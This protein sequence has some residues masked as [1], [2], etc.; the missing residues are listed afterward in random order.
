MNNDGVERLRFLLSGIAAP[1]LNNPPSN[2][3][4]IQFPLSHHT[5]PTFSFPPTP[6]LI[7]NQ[8]NELNF[9]NEHLERVALI[10]KLVK[11]Q[12]DYEEKLLGPVIK[13]EKEIKRLESEL[14]GLDI[15]LNA[16]VTVAE[17]KRSLKLEMAKAKMSK[18]NQVKSIQEKMVEF[19]R[20]QQDA[21]K[22]AGFPLFAVSDKLDDLVK[23]HWILAPYMQELQMKQ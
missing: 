21:L 20:Y 19:R 15:I 8:F 22:S 12:E 6:T 11:E 3:S 9:K 7:S 13:L 14:E 10:E 23:Q 17:K 2:P 18:I 5:N 1:P 16:E 4:Q